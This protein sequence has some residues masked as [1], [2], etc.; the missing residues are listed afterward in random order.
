LLN[1]WKLERVPEPEEMDEAPEVASYSAA[2]AERHLN[3]IDDTFVGHLLRLLSP[4]TQ[5]ADALWGLDVGTGPA[6]IPIKLLMRTPR[7]RIIGLDRSANMLACARRDAQ[8][9]GVSDRFFLL[10]GDGHR[11]PF[12]DGTFSAVFCNSVLH[13]AHDP[14]QL[15]HEIFRVAHAGAAVLVRDLRRPARPLL[16]WHLWWHGRNYEGLMRQLFNAS[17]RASYTRDEVAAFLRQAQITERH[18]RATVFRYR[19]AH[20]GIERPARG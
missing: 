14:V 7:L 2:A 1:C 10:R 16:Q 3:A 9:A 11:L 19:G 4:R 17:V 8:R 12:A 18:P 6:Q 20:L 5:T 13:H 15:L